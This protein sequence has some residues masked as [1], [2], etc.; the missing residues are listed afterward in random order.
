MEVG[1]SVEAARTPTPAAPPKRVLVSE[2]EVV[3]GP[4]DRPFVSLVVNA[5]AGFTP[6]EEIL[7][8]LASRAVRTTFFLMGWWAERNPDL[9]RHIQAGG[10][11][12]ASHGHT[13]FDLTQASDAGIT[14]DLEGADTA[15][16]A[17]TGQ[18]TR[19]LWSASAGYRDARVRR[20]AAQMGYR[21]IFWTQ[22]SGDWREDATAEDVRRRVLA[23]AAPGAIIVLHLD[24]V[25]SHSATASV[26]GEV[27]DTLRLRGLEPVTITELVGE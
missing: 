25:R 18:S 1:G 27:I 15:I 4:P 2:E 14:A 23:G 6:A 21:P 19:P 24:S 9:V 3:R 11:E 26:L 10:H 12:I 13:V 8:V 20:I 22:D 17:I 16:S 5:G 7:D